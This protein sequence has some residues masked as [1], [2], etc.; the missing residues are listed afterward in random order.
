MD[1]CR[2]CCN[3]GPEIATACLRVRDAATPA[4]RRA[5]PVDR[6]AARHGCF[7]VL[8]SPSCCP[9]PPA[10]AHPRRAP[11]GRPCRAAGIRDWEQGR[12]PALRCQMRAGAR[13]AQPSMKPGLRYLS[14]YTRRGG[15]AAAFNLTNGARCSGV[16]QRIDAIAQRRISRTRG[17]SRQRR[18]LVQARRQFFSD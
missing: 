14:I 12:P 5:R 18:R 16:P 1:A 13:A 7:Q 3:R 4:A 10:G 8:I 6:G 2:S 17:K 9:T 11:M 15:A